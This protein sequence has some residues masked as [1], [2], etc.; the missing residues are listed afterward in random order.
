MDLSI[1][2]INYK[3]KSVTADCL[4]SIKASTDQLKKEVIIVDNGSDDGSIEYLAKRFP[5]AKVVSSGGNIGF[6]GGNNFGFKRS[7]GKYVW[8]LNSDTTLQKTTIQKLY[9]A[10]VAKNSAIA[11]CRLL[12]R[13]GSIQPQGGY[14]PFLF[15]LKMWMLF[16]D[17]LPIVSRFYPAYHVNRKSYFKHDQKP[18]WV[19]G[20]AMLIRRDVY[21]KLNGLDDKIFMYSEDT[22]FCLRAKKL[23]FSV[24]Y[25]ALPALTHLGQAS[26][27]SRGALLGEYKGL[28]YI[29][30][31]H[32][33]RW[34]YLA[35]RVLLK[36]G[37]IM[38]RVIFRNKIY[39]EAF[40]LA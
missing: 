26:G 29:Y 35:L 30:Q 40:K 37:A 18:G 24:D 23:D 33:P 8:L 9:E 19:A 10:A 3:T 28:K 13:D 34:Q 5:W 6:A 2:I 14:L 20:T 22:E 25:F 1:V 31:K 38:R 21:Q 4:R 16:I 39:D 12:N 7:T 17:D 11:S 36:T 15:R 27:S 32:F